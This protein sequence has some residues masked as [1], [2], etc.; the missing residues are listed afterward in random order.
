MRPCQATNIIV[1]ASGVSWHSAY[2]DLQGPRYL[3]RYVHLYVLVRYV[4]LEGHVRP[5]LASAAHN[6]VLGKVAR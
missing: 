3:G 2:F 4:H 6:V 5:F 1:H